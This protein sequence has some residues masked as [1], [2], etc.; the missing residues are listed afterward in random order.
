MTYMVE[1]NKT[2]SVKISLSA[3]DCL[4]KLVKER[5]IGKIELVNR[6]IQ[7]LE[8]QDRTVQAIVLGQIEEEDENAIFEMIKARKA[9]KTVVKAALTRSGGQARRDRKN[10]ESES[11]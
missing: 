11:A 2:T 9:A 6:A 7:W 3:K 1:K 4:D 5:G 8:Q 10:I